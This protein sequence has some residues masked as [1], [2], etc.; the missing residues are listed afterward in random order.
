M[1]KNIIFDIGGII[2]D[3]SDDNLSKVLG[4]DLS[5]LISKIHGPIFKEYLAGKIDYSSYLNSFKNDVA[6]AYSGDLF[7]FLRTSVNWVIKFNPYILFSNF[8]WV[9]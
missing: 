2:L 3:D 8:C 9:K 6:L 5:S 1:I 4:E 7:S